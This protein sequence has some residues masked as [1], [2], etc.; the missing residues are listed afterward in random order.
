MEQLED[1]WSKRCEHCDEIKPAR[2]HH[3][4]VSGTCVF[5]MD[6]YCPWVNNCVGLENYR[7][8]LLFTLYLTIGCG[9]MCVTITAIH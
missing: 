6:H 4:R 5:L 7:Y 3:C 8:F 1:F 2:A 9:Y